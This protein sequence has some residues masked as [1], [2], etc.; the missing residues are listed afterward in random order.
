MKSTDTFDWEKYL[1]ECLSSTEYFS[2]ATVDHKGVWVNPVYF[3]WDEDFTF[4]FIS[5]LHSRHMQN[6]SKDKR[7]SVAIYKT[8]Q[9]GDV[10]GVQLEGEAAILS[11]QDDV[12]KAFAIYHHRTG[13]GKEQEEY[14]T[15]PTWIFV[16]ITPQHLYY[17]DTRF[18][19]E[20]RQEVPLVKI[21]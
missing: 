7:V 17:F 13:G 19:D 9:K 10:Q 14:I 8:E 12:E 5:Q 1:I 2:L 20:E 3:A 21:H 4:Y 16:K 15:N 6:I 11:N 18:F